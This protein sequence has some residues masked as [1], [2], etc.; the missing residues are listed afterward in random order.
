MVYD[1]ADNLF[2]VHVRGQPGQL[3]RLI[4]VHIGAHR[5]PQGIDQCRRLGDEPRQLV[6][7]D[8]PLPHGHNDRLLP[9]PPVKISA[10]GHP[11]AGILERGLAIHV[12]PPGLDVKWIITV[13]FI[14]IMR[15]V[16]RLWNIN[17]NP[18]DLVDED[19]ESDKIDPHEKVD[20]DAQVPGHRI[21]GQRR[22][23]AGVIVHFAI[24]M[25]PVDAVLEII[26]GD[27]D[28]QVTRDG[29]HTGAHGHRIQRQNEHRVGAPGTFFTLTLVDAH[30][31]HI[32]TLVSAPTGQIWQRRGVRFRYRRDGKGRIRQL[33][34][35]LICEIV[36]HDNINK[37]TGHK[38]RADKGESEG[39]PKPRR[40]LK[41][42][43]HR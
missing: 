16:D 25:G 22:P 1:G 34:D 15:V 37:I 27:C 17:I 36:T 2:R 35:L 41:P 20:G 38:Q 11:G 29:E 26:A 3:Q 21:A 32:H 19:L 24:I 39:A 10:K 33:D 8:H 6:K 12:L 4:H 13:F 14:R 30:Q 9:L 40:D 23:A 28:P 31:Q 42:T 18:A 43:T 7:L 5:V